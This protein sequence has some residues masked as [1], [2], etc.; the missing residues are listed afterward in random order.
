MNQLVD[1]YQSEGLE[2]FGIPTAQFHNQDPGE[3]DEILNSLKHVRPGNGFVPKIHMLAK[4]EMNGDAALPMITAFKD[5]CGPI[6]Y[7]TIKQQYVS[8]SPV[9]PND[10]AWNFEKF[11]LDRQGRP[12]RRYAHYVKPM[13]ITADIEMVLS[14]TGCPLRNEQIRCMTSSASRR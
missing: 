4:A 13:S 5:A 10:M 14:S 12:C 7:T 11:L 8:W 3:G 1:R 6:P 9:R 2:V